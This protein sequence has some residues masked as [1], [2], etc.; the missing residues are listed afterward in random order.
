MRGL[1]AIAQEIRG[2]S[3]SARAA[4]EECLVLLEER[5]DLGA[6]WHVDAER[7]LAAADAVDRLLA[8]GCDPGPLG[9]VPI[10][11]KDAFAVAG[12][13][14]GAG[15]PVEIA[16]RD[17]TVVRRLRR[18]GAIVVGTCA[19]HQLGWGMSGQTPGR[20]TC[21]NPLDPS[22]QPGGSSSGSA[23]AVA[24]GIVPLALG[25]DTGG[26]VRQPGQP[27]AGSSGTSLP[28]V[29]WRVAGSCRCHRPSTRWA[30]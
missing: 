25:G 27:G 29:R 12:M 8:D 2:G 1:R 13:P 9:G 10:A 18:T 6:F 30:G 3:R 20:P 23:V 5:S 21:R 11:V 4:C 22:L 15:G 19:M 26:S 28:G 16:R 7:A 24:A 17:A 14:G